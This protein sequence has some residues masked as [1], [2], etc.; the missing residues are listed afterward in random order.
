MKI[1]M[2]HYFINHFVW[3]CVY[4][5][6]NDGPTANSGKISFSFLSVVCTRKLCFHTPGTLYVLYTYIYILHATKT[7][8][9]IYHQNMF[10]GTVLSPHSLTLSC[11]VVY[12]SVSLTHTVFLFTTPTFIFYWNYY[13]VSVFVSVLYY[14]LYVCRKTLLPYC[15]TIEHLFTTVQKKLLLGRTM[16]QTFRSICTHTTIIIFVLFTL[17]SATWKCRSLVLMDRNDL[18]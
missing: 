16:Y 7:S 4:V 2:S 11:C 18:K 12:L 15:W 5:S 9:N 13:H 8:F 10:H 3:K 14:N 17:H 6:R 1:A